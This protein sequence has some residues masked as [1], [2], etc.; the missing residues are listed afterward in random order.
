MKRKDECIACS[1]RACYERVVSTDG[2]KAYDE[3][4]CVEHVQYLHK[5]SD[6]K[7]PGIRKHFICS[8]GKQK[9][10]MEVRA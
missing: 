10:G 2:G 1:R 3:V 6:A 4:S 9:R 8:T 5:D 7:A